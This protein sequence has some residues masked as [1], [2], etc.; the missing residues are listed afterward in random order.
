[1]RR[2][3]QRPDGP[4]DEDVPAGHVAGLAGDLGAAPRQ[5]AGLVGE[6]VGGEADAVG[7]ERRGLD[8]VGAGR[9]VLAVDRADQLGPRQDELVEAARCGIPREKSSVP[10]APSAS[11]GPWARRSR[12]RALA[13]T[14]ER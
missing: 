7:A 4:G 8:Q 3:A 12:N 13:S 11:N 5:P 9:E 2:S 6:T 1:M 14:P 10:I